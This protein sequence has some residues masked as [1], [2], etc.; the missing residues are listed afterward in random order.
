MSESYDNIT[1]LQNGRYSV[2][3]KLGEGGK[4]IVF[5]CKDNSLGR[6]VAVKLI[7]GDSLDNETFSRLMREAQTTAKLSHTN[8]VSIYDLIKEGDR[9][10]MVIEY[11]DGQSLD[12]YVNNHGGKLSVQEA[13]E[14]TLKIC[15]AL[16]YAHDN[17]I[18]HRDIKP[19]NIMISGNGNP[20]LM[21]FGLAKS[22][23]SPGLTHAGT[24]VGTPAYLAPESALGKKADARSDLYSIGCVLYQMLTGSPPFRS[25]DSLKLIYSH[26]HDHPLPPSKLNHLVPQQIDS[27]VMKLL[28]KNPDERYN[29]AEELSQAL[30]AV[31]ATIS[32]AEKSRESVTEERKAAKTSG[33]LLISD[34]RNSPVGLDEQIEELKNLADNAVMGIGKSVI[35][36]G[37][38]GVG[39][40]RIASEIRDYTVL[41]GMRTITVKCRDNR[42]NTPHF[43]FT[44]V[45]REYLYMAPQQLIYKICGD[46]ADVAVKLL[47]DLEGKLGKIIQP[48]SQDPEVLKARF[49]DGTAS[50]INNMAA[51]NP[52]CIIVEDAHYAD[53]T[54]VSI[55][56]VVSDTIDNSRILLIVTIGN[57]PD[58]QSSGAVEG[59]LAGR[60]FRQINLHP[61]DR[62]N[63][64]KFISLYLTEPLKNISDEFLDF[65][66]NRTAGNPLYIEEVLKYLIEKKIIFKSSSG[67]WDRKPIDNAGIPGSL[68]GIIRERLSGIDDYSTN[69]MANASVI[70]MEFDV[71][72]LSELMGDT[73]EKFY[74]SL[75]K[76]IQ[77]DLL[78]ERE[79]EM[80]R[81]KLFFPN[82]QVYYYFF[83]QFS[84]LKKRRLHQKIAELL[85]KNTDHSDSS[86]ISDIAGHF[87]HGGLPERAVPYLIKIGDSWFQSYEYEKALQEYSEAYEILGK[88]QKQ[89]NEKKYSKDIAEICYK[90]CLMG[91][92]ILVNG[93]EDYWNRGIREFEKIE[94]L[95]GQSRM[96]RVGVLQIRSGNVLERAIKFIEANKNNESL[97]NIILSIAGSIVYRFW[98]ENKLDEAKK[99]DLWIREFTK[100]HNVERKYI[101]Y[102]DLFGGTLLREIRSQEDIDW[103]I[104]EASDFEK[105]VSDF[106]EETEESFNLN[107]ATGPIFYDFYGDFVTTLKMDLLAGDKIF[108][109]GLELY[110][111]NMGALYGSFYISEYVCSVM[112]ESGRWDEAQAL[113]DKNELLVSEEKDN[114]LVFQARTM[115]LIFEVTKSLYRGANENDTDDLRQ[116]LKTISRQITGYAKDIIP[117]VYLELNKPE[118][119]EDYI[120]ETMDYIRKT[121]ITID[122]IQ[123]AVMLPSTAV[124]I[125]SIQGNR[126]KA[127]EYLS[128]LR[129]YS[130]KFDEKWIKC[131]MDKAEASYE[132][133]FGE[134]KNA[135][136]KMKKVVSYFKSSGLLLKYA[137]S[138]LELAKMYHKVGDWKNGSKNVTQALDIFTKLDCGSYVK[139]CLSL[140]ELLKA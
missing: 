28:N 140:M 44:E 102:Y 27:I 30:K 6:I 1:S 136:E 138:S 20:K 108:T 40:T 53:S 22:F 87:I 56:K 118:K 37:D 25:E 106:S 119:A 11:V 9:F 99:F 107:R 71:D 10:I 111:K 17:G 68:V 3:K 137:E 74:D 76:L 39:K 19:E 81:I 133:Y 114:D 129:D 123:A 23:D 49:Q 4:G 72:I 110:G 96:L 90:I 47:P 70:G 131:F 65:I 92:F 43:V 127:E 82:P 101:L 98:D 79:T 104:F 63:T 135:I 88:M 84:L 125:Y 97:E 117:R 14:I 83:D 95:Y 26:I 78:G 13:I 86:S 54:S 128:Y 100:T 134:I 89:G 80:G 57:V 5:K 46:Y 61:L 35:I 24:I 33:T 41:R 34:Y 58:S 115:V 59:L 73:S 31:R 75:E 18:L 55:L 21:D 7:K 112:L 12:S 36:S 139:K 69:I 38:T 60:R 94:D 2:I 64:R 121:A 124:D 50:I 48:A 32:S 130:S 16:Q 51:E 67:S 103:C 126:K 62:E 132:L 120:E 15:D 8:I 93:F 52:L 29:S 45:M 85:E 113:I 109:K 105:Y 91:A 42:R 116:R 77:K 122:L 66:F